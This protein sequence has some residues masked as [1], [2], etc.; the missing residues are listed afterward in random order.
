MLCPEI[1]AGRFEEVFEQIDSFRRFQGKDI[2]LL[3]ETVNYLA[4][5]PEEQREEIFEE[6]QDC[7]FLDLDGWFFECI[8]DYG[9]EH[10]DEMRRV[11]EVV[12]SFRIPEHYLGDLAFSLAQAG[13]REEALQQVAANLERWPE[14]FE[15]R[16]HAGDVYVELGD[17][18]KAL[19]VYLQALGLA[20]HAHDWDR[21][22]ERVRPLLKRLGRQPEWRS[23]KER[24][25]RPAEQV[26]S[27]ISELDDDGPLGVITSGPTPE[28]IIDPSFHTSPNVNIGRNDPCPC[29]SGKKYKKCCLRRN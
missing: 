29:G 24:Y 13:R 10:P 5:F 12:A 21:V 4:R 11:A 9:K 23:I 25:P 1:I 6:I 2:L 26:L 28:V 8:L 15:I 18:E 3:I 20:A 16:T 22:A 27:V 7:A 14:I 17:N 19:E